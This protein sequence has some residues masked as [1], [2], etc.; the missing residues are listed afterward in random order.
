MNSNKKKEVPLELKAQATKLIDLIN[1]QEGSV[2][3][4]EII[5]KKLEQSLYLPLMKDKV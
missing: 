2:V 1:Y 5:S 3:S 4:R